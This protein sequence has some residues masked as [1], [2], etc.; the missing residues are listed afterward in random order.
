MNTK[1]IECKGLLFYIRPDTTDE[2]VVPEVVKRHVY[3]RKDFTIEVGE[4][5]ADIG[6][7]IGTFSCFAFQRGAKVVSYEPEQDNFELLQRNLGVNKFAGNSINKAVTYSGDDA[8]LYT[9]KSERNK[10]RHSIFPHKG[11][12]MVKIPAVSFVD[13]LSLGV[14]CVKMDIEGAEF[15]IFDKCAD[16]GNVRKLAFE[17][18]FDIDKKIANFLRRMDVLSRHFTNIYYS[19]LPKGEEYN[20]FPAAKMVYCQR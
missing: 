12:G 20:F 8:I 14:D 2:K 4:Y 10:Y 5:W 11:W 17:Y 13:V 6:A 19:K 7:N 9:C 15:E 18:H 16:W 3:T 1:A